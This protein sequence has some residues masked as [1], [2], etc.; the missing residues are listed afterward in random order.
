MNGETQRVA[1][2][3]GDAPTS[4]PV[5]T[6]ARVTAP[7]IN[8]FMARFLSRTIP[9]FLFL[10]EWLLPPTFKVYR[11]VCFFSI[12]VYA[13]DD[14]IL[15]KY[16][17]SGMKRK[18]WA[19]CAVVVLLCAPVGYLAAR[20][21]VVFTALTT[22]VL[23]HHAHVQYDMDVSKN[24]TE[25]EDEGVR[26]CSVVVNETWRR[27]NA[28]YPVPCGISLSEGGNVS[29]V[30]GIF[31]DEVVSLDGVTIWHGEPGD[32]LQFFSAVVYATSYF[33][34][35]YTVLLWYL[36]RQPHVKYHP[37]LKGIVVMTACVG[38]MVCYAALILVVPLFNGDPM[39]ALLLGLA[40]SILV[41]WRIE[42]GSRPPAAEPA[43]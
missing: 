39:L 1:A 32:Q 13:T 38:L 24:L 3:A 25:G 4:T 21:V 36:R 14:G 19:W 7:A 18:K 20:D 30:P 11:A 23:E 29:V 37:S 34:V 9:L 10:V 22:H 33:A 26:D 16:G 40:A 35:L 8:P 43:D 41:G 17:G 6:I 15:K 42:V 12:I 31:S 5:P 28:V 2:A 27:V